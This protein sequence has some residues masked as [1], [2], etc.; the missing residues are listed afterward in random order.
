[1]IKCTRIN[2]CN[3]IRNFN[4]LNLIAGSIPICKT[5]FFWGEGTLSNFTYRMSTKF[6]RNLYFVIV[7]GQRIVC[8][9]IL[10]Q[11]SSTIII[12]RIQKISIL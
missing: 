8:P 2:I 3:T 10:H 6:R 11:C 12:Y 4:F 9:N 5:T 7:C 1:M